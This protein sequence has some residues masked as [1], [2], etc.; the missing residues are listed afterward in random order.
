M[1]KPYRKIYT[2]GLNIPSDW[3]KQGGKW[4]GE[5]IDK[6]RGAGLFSEA[7]KERY[8]VLTQ[9]LSGVEL[10]AGMM[11]KGKMFPLELLEPYNE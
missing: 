7:A 4:L 10:I 11:K 5:V 6:L 3:W 2:E 8:P 1:F 9:W